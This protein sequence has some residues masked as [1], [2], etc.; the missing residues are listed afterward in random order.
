[1]CFGC[2]YDVHLIV[3]SQWLMLIE[4]LCHRTNIIPDMLKAVNDLKQNVNAQFNE[5]KDD[6]NIR[7]VVI[8]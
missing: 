8:K 5:P 3:Y 4:Q 2:R 7:E 6:I 1:M